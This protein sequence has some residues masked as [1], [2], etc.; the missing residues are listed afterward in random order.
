MK[1]HKSDP[2]RKRVYRFVQ[3]T[4][5]QRGV[6][7]RLRVEDIHVYE[8]ENQILID[9]NDPDGIPIYEVPVLRGHEQVVL[10][11]IAGRAPEEQV[12]PQLP[13]G[14]QLA[15]FR[16]QY[17]RDLYHYIRKHGDLIHTEEQA[18]RYVLH[19]LA[20]EER[21]L[22]L[23]RTRFLGLCSRRESRNQR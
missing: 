12:F 5:L 16:M 9:V 17:A 11:A 22:D 13:R 6:L 1:E 2:E 20:M 8:D 18:V 3:A 7:A 4:G 10:S 15:P 21:H 23:V 19:A 14:L